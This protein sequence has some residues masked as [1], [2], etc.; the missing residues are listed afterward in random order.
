MTEVDSPVAIV[1]GGGTGIGRAVAQAFA[2]GGL[3]VV[4]A[5]RRRAQ[6]DETVRL[7]QD[8][9]GEAFFVQT[10]VSRADEVAA[11]VARALTAYGRVDCACNSAG[12]GER[13]ALLADQTEEDFERTISVNLKGVWLCMKHEIAAMRQTGGGAIVNISSLN[14]VKVAPTAPFYSASKAGVD[15]LTKAAALGYARDSIRVNSIDAGAFR[16]P[17]LDGVLDRMSGGRP[18]DAAAQYAAAI[19][20]G[21]IG[22]PEEIARAVVWL[23]SE[24]A[25][26]ITG[27]VLVVDGGLLAT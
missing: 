7:I 9:G 24:A 20:L 21:R 2:Q 26:Y 15:A 16:T 3:R 6:G 22:R 23:C 1:T 8:A 18:E 12:T 11:L 25:S 19:P 5:G 27:H 10:D 13:E 17:M 4:V 14:A